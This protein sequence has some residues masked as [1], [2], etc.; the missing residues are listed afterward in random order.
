MFSGVSSLSLSDVNY[1]LSLYFS[2]LLPLFDVEVISDRL[3]FIKKHGAC[4]GLKCVYK[5]N[6]TICTLPKH[7]SKEDLYA[8]LGISTQYLFKELTR[9]VSVTNSLESLDKITLMYSPR[10]RLWVFVTIF[11]SRNTD[12][13]MNTIKWVNI[14][15]DH[16]CFDT[17][18]K[19]FEDIASYQ[20][21]QFVE[22]H[23]DIAS[24]LTS[25]LEVLDEA[26]KLLK[27]KHVG[28]KTIYAYLLH[29]HGYTQYAPIDRYYRSLLEELGV[30]GILPGKTTC[31]D[32]SLKCS[33][34]KLYSRCLYAKAYRLFGK[35]NGVIQSLS[36]IYGRLQKAVKHWRSASEV[37]KTLIEKIDVDKTLSELEILI[38]TLKE[39]T[40]PALVAPK[41]F[42]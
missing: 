40:F 42:T 41:R 36:Y 24:I 3:V 17:P 31:I 28:L 11:L 26:L 9:I 6:E 12:Y 30:R 4:K 18:N 29:A 39:H 38:S 22:V 14:M 37:E 10:D 25:K 33:E 7:C 27:L 19:C 2:Y 8:I 1:A 20:Y 32:H 35:Y 16:N 15:L 5:D 21:R 13:Y 23:K 34:C